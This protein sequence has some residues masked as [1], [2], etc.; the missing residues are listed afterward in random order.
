MFKSKYFDLGRQ[1]VSQRVSIEIL[2]SS[3]FASEIMDAM[4]R[5][6]RKDWGIINSTDANLNEQAIK[7]GDR[8]LGAY[9][10]SKGKIYI[11]TEWDRSATIILFPDEG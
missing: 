9:M 7:D 11:I 3:L 2:E 8:L 4:S 6:C 5:Y 1:V 10:T